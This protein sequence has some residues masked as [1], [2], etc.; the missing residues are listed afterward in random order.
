MQ[1]AVSRHPL[2]MTRDVLPMQAGLSLTEMLLE[3]QPDP[4]LRE[5]VR[6]FVRGEEVPEAWWPQVR[7]KP[8]AVVSIVL[9]PAGGGGKNILGIVLGLAVVAAGFAFGAPLLGIG[10]GLGIL[11]AVLAPVPNVENPRLGNAIDRPQLV[12]EGARNQIRPFDVIPVMLGKRPVVPPKL[13]PVREIAG[14]QVFLRELFVV[15]YGPLAL[16]DIK[17]GETPIGQFEGVQIEVLQGWPGDPPP[18]LYPNTP[19]ERGFSVRLHNDGG[20]VGGGPFSRRVSEPD[21]DEFSIDILFPNGLIFFDSR[22]RQ[23]AVPAT[24][25]LRWRQLGQ[26]HWHFK[27]FTVS[28]ATR[29]AFRISERVWGLSRGQYEVELRRIDATGPAGAPTPPATTIEESIWE[30]LRSV[31]NES[32]ITPGGPPL[33]LIALRIKASDQLNGFIEELS[34]IA[35]SILPDY[36]AGTD[37]ALPWPVRETANPASLLRHVYGGNPNPRPAEADALPDQDLADFHD[38]CRERGFTYNRYHDSE[39]SV[40]DAAD[41]ICAVAR[42]SRNPRDGVWSVVTDRPQDLPVAAFSP[43]NLREFTWRKNFEEEPPHALRV[44]FDNEEQGWRRDERFVY[45]GGFT[46]DTATL[47]R[48]L[49]LPGVTNAD[50]AYRMGAFHLAQFTHRS[51]VFSWVSPMASFRVERGDRIEVQHDAVSIGLGSGRVKSAGDDGQG[52]IIALTF[53]AVFEIG[54][55]RT[56]GLHL[57]LNDDRHFVLRLLTEAGETATLSLAEPFAGTEA[58]LLDAHGLF[59]ELGVEVEDLVV[60]GLEPLRDD[61]ARITAVRHAE[62]IDRAGEGLLPPFVSTL[63][64]QPGVEKPFVTQV[65]SGEAVLRR[66]AGGLLLP[67]IVVTYG[68][69]W[70]RQL[71]RIEAIEAQVRELGEEQWSSLPLLPAEAMQVS[72]EAVEQGGTYE[73]RHRYR[74]AGGTASPWTAVLSETVIGK[75]TPPPDVPR[76]SVQN[77]RLFWAYPDPPSDLRGFEVR[78]GLG[79]DIAWDDAQPLSD[80]PIAGT[81]IDI[82][83]F[84][85]GAR[86]FLIRALDTAGNLSANPARTLVQATGGLGNVL[87]QVDEHPGW[88]GEIIAGVVEG[89]VLKGAISS[90]ALVVNPTAPLIADPAAPLIDL[91]YEGIVYEWLVAVTEADLPGELRVDFASPGSDIAFSVFAGGDEPI[92][93]DLAAPLIADPAAPLVPSI[94]GTIPFP[95]VLPLEARGYRLRVVLP[96]GAT[97]P[98]LTALSTLVDVADQVER[99]SGVAIAPGGTTLNLTKPFRS[100]ADVDT[101]LLADGGTGHSVR[102]KVLANPPVVEVLD[103]AGLSVAGTI[104]A[105]VRGP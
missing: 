69:R 59:G 38:W 97:R 6:I 16:S 77:N 67:R 39:S 55:D 105:T 89:G 82:T 18:T 61:D 80:T 11:G 32:P 22:G 88:N 35:S 52:N 47:I 64:P 9:L 103:E 66:S 73:H 81:S 43:R 92:V 41:A 65:Q 78:W 90:G 50:Q 21:I 40:F 33:A 98:E 12:L 36:E 13:R 95:G 83:C 14:D 99:L 70:A 100:V 10:I 87:R 24:F 30:V 76:T 27:H 37:P 104:N 74:F 72:I 102:I 58:E 1:V 5:S 57:W 54:A 34:V 20:A 17:I 31:T 23:G 29:G 71:R 4:R 68:A 94:T 85:E 62:E 28:R 44:L 46:R 49:E 56:Y 93:A 25:L 15:G 91:A 96:A 7:P 3:A 8:G 86:T 101:N 60:I 53:D 48:D 51:E 63:T 42:S 75:S 45:R 79:Q 26:A 2:R 84:C 19:I